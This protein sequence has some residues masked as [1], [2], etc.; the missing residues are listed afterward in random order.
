M[1]EV[2]LVEPF[3]QIEGHGFEGH[4]GMHL[5]SG[6][7][8]GTDELK[9]PFEGS[10]SLLNLIADLGNQAIKAFLGSGQRLIDFSLS[11]DAA[12]DIVLFQQT[13]IG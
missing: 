10:K 1:C 12:L 9:P 3:E 2:D 4:L 7:V 5:Y 11:H 13:L 8:G 6:K